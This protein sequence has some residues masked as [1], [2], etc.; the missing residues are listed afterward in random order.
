MQRGAYAAVTGIEKG[1]YAV[2]YNGVSGYVSGD[3]VA[4]CAAAG[5]VTETP[6]EAPSRHLLRHRR[7]KR[8]L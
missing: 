1:W 7:R 3:Y 5:T 2:S 4:L 6:A 8:L